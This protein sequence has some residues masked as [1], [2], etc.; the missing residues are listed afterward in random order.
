MYSSQVPYI[1]WP[2]LCHFVG[3]SASNCL[4]NPQKCYLRKVNLKIRFKVLANLRTRIIIRTSSLIFGFDNKK[5]SPLISPIFQGET[6]E[7][8]SFTAIKIMTWNPFLAKADSEFQSERRYFFVNKVKARMDS[9]GITPV[10]M[11]FELQKRG[12]TVQPPMLSSILRGVYTYP[13]AK[14]ILAECEKI[15]DERSSDW[16]SDRRPRKTVG[17]Y[18]RRILSRPGEWERISDMATKD[19]RALS[20]D[21]SLHYPTKNFN[22]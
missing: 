19:N 8:Y 16:R 13:K 3:E 11:I 18:P 17:E 21:N 7:C 22:P 2:D 15:L 12:M 10:D 5:T 4:Q 9:L 6:A 1:K 14:R 20:D